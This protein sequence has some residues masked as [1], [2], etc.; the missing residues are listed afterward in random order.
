MDYRA[1]LLDEHGR[2][3]DAYAFVVASD[4]AALIHAH[5]YANGLDVEVWHRARRVGLIPREPKSIRLE[6]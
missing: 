6:D 3:V 1:Y 4:E 5:Q 2:I